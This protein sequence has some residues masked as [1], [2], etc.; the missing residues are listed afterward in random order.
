MNKNIYIYKK[1]SREKIKKPQETVTQTRIPKIKM[2]KKQKENH[3]FPQQFIK[4]IRPGI[5]ARIRRPG[6]TR[7]EHLD[8]QKLPPFHQRQTKKKNH[9]REEKKKGIYLY[10][11]KRITS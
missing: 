10:K 11:E 3:S 8:D 1:K 5:E 6:S 9:P 4:N 2:P 7:K